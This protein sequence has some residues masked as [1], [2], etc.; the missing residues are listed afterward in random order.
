M[1]L[2]II[3]FFSFFSQNAL[4]ATTIGDTT[5]P[6]DVGKTYTWKLTYPPQGKGMKFS[7]KIESIE[8]GVHDS[9]DALMVNCTFRGYMP[10]GGWT[11]IVDNEL[12]MAANSTQNY[13]AFEEYLYPTIIP[14]PLNLTLVAEA[15]Y[16]YN[17]S[18]INNTIIENYSGDTEE[19]TYN[20][21]GFLTSFVST[22]EGELELKFVLD[23]GGDGAIP[24][25][26][27]FLIFMIVSVIALIYLKKQKIK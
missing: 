2:L 23:T 8:K 6:A 16:L 26:H 12:Y 3:F 19:Y 25:G 24:F 1:A 17:Y 11:T 4:G 22:Y 13:L 14:T 20:D 10:I 15:I 5:F 9:M 21:N 18:I 7:A 27:F